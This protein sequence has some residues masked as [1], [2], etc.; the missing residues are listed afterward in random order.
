S[1][2]CLA[3]VVP[4]RRGG[5]F[6]P[7]RGRGGWRGGVWGGG[8]FPI[9]MSRPPTRLG[10]AH[11]ATLPTARPSR[12]FPTWTNRYMAEPGNTW[13]RR[14]EGKGAAEIVVQERSDSDRHTRRLSRA[15]R[16]GVHGAEARA[17]CL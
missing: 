14:G 11:R 4:P 17:G 2:A 13:V 16:Q 5:A 15:I 7:P 9:W 12:M 6:P 10:A 3:M 8:H 1:G